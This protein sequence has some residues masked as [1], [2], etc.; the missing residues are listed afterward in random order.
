MKMFKFNTKYGLL[1]VNSEVL[2]HLNDIEIP[3]QVLYTCTGHKPTCSDFNLLMTLINYSVVVNCN[4][5]GVKFT[6]W[7]RI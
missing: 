7:P 3:V 2:V 4:H 1:L 6:W 5:A